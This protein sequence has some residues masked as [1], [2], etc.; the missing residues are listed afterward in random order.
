MLNLTHHAKER[1]K[2]RAIGDDALAAALAGREVSIGGQLFYYDRR[3]RTIV[4]TEDNAIVTCYRLTKSEVK[5][6]LSR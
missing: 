6:R 5:R 4:V 1:L 2:L 3:T